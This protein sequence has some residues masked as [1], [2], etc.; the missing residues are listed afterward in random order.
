ME[1]NTQQSEVVETKEEET[2]EEP[3]SIRETLA[4]KMAEPEQPQKPILNTKDSQ[5]VNATETTPSQPLIAVPP[6]LKGE[7]KDKFKTYPPEMQSEISRLLYE[8]QSDHTRKIA[9]IKQQ[10]QEYQEL[11]R[12]LNPEIRQAYAREGISAP[13]IV[14]RSIAW[15][16]E[17]K[18]P[19]KIAAAR[20][21]LEAYGIYPED[22]LSDDYQQPQ[23]EYLT[24]EEAA[25]L[26]QQEV[27]KIIEKERSSQ[28]AFS[29]YQAVQSFLS[30]KPLFKDPQTASQLE[31]AMAEE[32]IGLRAAYEARGQTYSPQELLST[33]YDRVTKIHPVF[34]N[35]IQE[36]AKRQEAERQHQQALKAQAA[37]RSIKG[38]PGQGTPTIKSGNIRESLERNLG[39]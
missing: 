37:S 7:H 34:S 27:Q 28:L 33:A 32:I 20:E 4:A 6:Y 24:K 29:N 31:E 12:V 15:D 9:Q 25:E 14:E 19:N 38:S 36:Q 30:E 35:L 16:R 18:S 8:Y 3:K 23:Q 1:D 39:R 2:Q 13:Q 17:L 22:L 26:A 10:E 21:Y 5:M 11:G